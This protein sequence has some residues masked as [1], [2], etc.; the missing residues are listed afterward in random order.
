[1]ETGQVIKGVFG[2]ASERDALAQLTDFALVQATLAGNPRAAE[3]F[4]DRFSPAAER[5]I[6]K[7]LP[8]SNAW[9]DALS[10]TFERALTGMVKQGPDDKVRAWIMGIGAN[11]AR[12]YR[13]SSRRP[14]WQT[15]DN[16]DIELAAE[17]VNLEA[18]EAV[19]AVHSVC[20]KMQEQD[21]ELVLLRWFSTI[22]LTELAE[23][24]GVSLAT[25]KR[26]LVRAETTFFGLAAV[27][28][29]LVRWSERFTKIGVQ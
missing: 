29:K 25:I 5:V 14:H 8:F 9:D 2:G 4:F 27:E 20:D 21:A 13:R 17:Q 7:L 28:P 10:E 6:C 3:V 16:D 11:V 23:M 15:A 26:H 22:E 24:R 18:R 19:R 1:M 12:E